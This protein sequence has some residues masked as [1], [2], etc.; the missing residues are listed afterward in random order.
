MSTLASIPNSRT[1]IQ[2]EESDEESGGD[3]EGEDNIYDLEMPPLMECDSDDEGLDSSWLL[4]EGVDGFA[5][6]YTDDN[7]DEEE[8]I[9][10]LS[11]R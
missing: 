10:A 1:N 8:G 4:N 2:Q 3:S 11:P 6:D 5:S 7:T 9:V